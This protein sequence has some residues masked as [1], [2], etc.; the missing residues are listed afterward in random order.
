MGED[1]TCLIPCYLDAKSVY[2][3]VETAYNCRC[4]EGSMSRLYS[5]RHFEDIRLGVEI[6]SGAENCGD[7][8]R[9]ALY[10]YAALCF[11]H[12]ASAAKAD[13]AAF[14]I[15]PGAFTRSV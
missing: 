4:R 14:W 7:N 12:F 2:V 8:V 9:Q 11:C 5:P 6:L 1:V 13:R 3:S 10:R 15:P